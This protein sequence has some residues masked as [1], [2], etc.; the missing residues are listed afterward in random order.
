MNVSGFFRARLAGS[1]QS[2]KEAALSYL[3]PAAEQR[4]RLSLSAQ[5]VDR[6]AQAVSAR[7]Y[8]E[9]G[10][11]KGA[12]FNA[13]R[14]PRKI[15]VDPRFQFDPIEFAEPGASFHQMT[16]DDYFTIERSE[17]FDIIFLDGLHTFQ[18]TFRDF[19]NALTRA[20]ERTV[21]LI[22]D[23]L[24]VDVYSAWP[25]AAESL[26][27]R[28]R[29]GGEG[30]AWHGDVFKLIFMIHDFFPTLSYRTIVGRGN[31]QAVV[32]K[33]PR[34]PFVPLF[35]T[36]EAIERLDYFDLLKK[37]DVLKSVSEA[38]MWDLLPSLRSAAAPVDPVR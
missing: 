23:V 35:K 32:W 22:D 2:I 29:G 5:R 7:S 33:A 20:H 27:F 36:V 31:P 34:E 28:Q 1:I 6:I 37:I 8:L 13:L 30:S 18:Q 25:N 19:C 3:K 26:S 15:A 14:F 16:S 4:L 11:A 17:V 38:E 12:T 10:V 21:W 9:I 24:P